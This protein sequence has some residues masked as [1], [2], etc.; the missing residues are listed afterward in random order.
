MNLHGSTISFPPRVDARG[1]VVTTARRDEVISQAI[2][3]LIETRRGERVML[4]DYGMPD[5]V[6]GVQDFSFAPRIAYL[7]RQQ[8]RRYVP[9]VKDVWVKATTDEDHRAILDVR[10]TEVGSITAPK[11]LV[12][13]V[14]N[15]QEGIA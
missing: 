10:Y 7:L 1:S 9:L 4:P 11:N 8:I 12:Y 15:L 6:F 13:P 14:W 5:F 2:A 3:D